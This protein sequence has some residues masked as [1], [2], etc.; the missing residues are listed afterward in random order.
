MRV[1]PG[2]REIVVPEDSRAIAPGS[3]ELVSP[4]GQQSNIEMPRC[5]FVDDLDQA[6]EVG[7]VRLPRIVVDE[8][9]ETECARFV[10]AVEFGER[11]SLNDGEALQGASTQVVATLFAGGAVNE[12]PGRVAESEEGSAVLGLQQVFARVNLHARKGLCGA[13]ERSGR[14]D[15]T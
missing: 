3:S 13:F 12:F 14:R 11:D 8:G 5:G 10:Q 2:I 15:P 7:W 6:I 1:S 9:L 4:G